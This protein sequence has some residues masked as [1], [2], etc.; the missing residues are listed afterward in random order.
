MSIFDSSNFERQGNTENDALLKNNEEVHDAIITLAS[1]ALRTIKIFTP[2]LEH[3]LYNNDE[4]RDALLAFSRGNRHAQIQILV[5]DSS[6]A[7][8]HGHRL[9]LLAQQLTSAMQIRNTP[10]DYQDTSISF[11]L[12]DQQGF[13]FKPD[14]SVQT[15]IQS[16]CQF[17]SNKLNEFYTSA[18]DQAEQDPQTR[19]FSI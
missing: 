4:F 1:N 5:T 16:N 14:S 11:I 18:W 8:H 3:A 15:A 6:M 7:I 17:R 13:I 2:D 12:I 19:R 9:I 10:E